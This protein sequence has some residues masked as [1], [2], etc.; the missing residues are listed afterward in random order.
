MG[1]HNP[2]KLAFNAWCYS[3]FP[4][5]LPAYPINYVIAHLSKIGYDGIELGCAS[6]VAYPS[7]LTPKDRQTIRK[8]LEEHRIE[9]SSVLPTPGRGPGNNV[10]SPIEA[11]RKSAVESYKDCIDLA[12]DLGSKMFLYIAGWVIYGVDQDQA[13]EWSKNALLSW[14]SMRVKRGVTIAIEP[15][16]N[17]TN[18]VETADDALKLMREA[19]SDNV[20]V[21]L[22][23]MHILSR[24][25]I[26][27]DYVEKMGSNLAHVHI[28]DLERTPP[29]TYT[30][31][32]FSLMRSGQTD[33]T[34]TFRLKWV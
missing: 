8:M 16:P 28:S 6:P 13:W 21:M 19:R 25:E 3:S 4:S 29:G 14:L 20:K 15:T 9:I 18:L 1:D 12:A 26:A 10:A 2:L 32:A 7:Y 22:D 11:E 27:T 24:R 5:W 34:G 23:T 31:F 17:D 30:D 33:M